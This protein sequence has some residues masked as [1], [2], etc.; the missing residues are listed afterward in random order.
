MPEYEHSAYKLMEVDMPDGG[1]KATVLMVEDEALIR[2]LGVELLEPPGSIRL[3]CTGV[4]RA[5]MPKAPVHKDR[6]ALARAVRTVAGPHAD[7]QVGRAGCGLTH[8]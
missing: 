8:T 7:P 5:P 4:N 1:S 2:M 6:H 3:G